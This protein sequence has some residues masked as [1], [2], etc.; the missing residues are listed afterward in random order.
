MDG[1]LLNIPESVSLALHAL[2]MLAREEGGMLTSKELAELT[3]MSANHL[4][5]VLRRL[6]VG[7]VLSASKGPGG[8]FYLSKE[9]QARNLIDVYLLFEPFPFNNGCIYETS[10]HCDKRKCVFGTLICDLNK[11][12]FEHFNNTTVGELSDNDCPKK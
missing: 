8:G 12:F 5:K 6:V 10:P 3:G 2:K 7:G 9:Q 4:S 1:R 11:R